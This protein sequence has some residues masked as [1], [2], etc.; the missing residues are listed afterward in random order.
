M[1]CGLL[2]T[3]HKTGHPAVV[4]LC[5]ITLTSKG[6]R[7]AKVNRGS[8]YTVWVLKTKNGSVVFFFFF[9]GFSKRELILDQCYTVIIFRVVCLKEGITPFPVCLMSRGFTARYLW[10]QSKTR[11]SRDHK[12]LIN[13]FVTHS[14]QHCTIM[15]W[16]DRTELLH[17][18]AVEIFSPLVLDLIW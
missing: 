5:K 6:S 14:G 11:H 7:I 8:W 12:E 13:L 18:L 4:E 3:A 10:T 16:S 17:I 9:N 1:W 2:W 15:K